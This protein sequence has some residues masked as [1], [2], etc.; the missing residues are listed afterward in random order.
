MMMPNKQWALG[1]G[2]NG[3]DSGRITVDLGNFSCSFFLGIRQLVLFNCS[4]LA[5][6]AEKILAL[7]ITGTT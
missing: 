7:N 4:G 6:L 3:D 5:I 2:E 1:S